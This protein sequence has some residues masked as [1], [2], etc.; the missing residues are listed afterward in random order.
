MNIIRRSEIA[1]LKSPLGLRIA[2]IET[3]L[4]RTFYT[5]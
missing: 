4:R 3:G 5:R 2:G 1:T